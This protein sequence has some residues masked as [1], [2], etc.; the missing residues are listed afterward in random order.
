[1]GLLMLFSSAFAQEVQLSDDKQKPE[2]V[3]IKLLDWL[4]KD[5]TLQNLD[6]SLERTKTKLFMGMIKTLEN[7]DSGNLKYHPELLK[8]WKSLSHIDP[9]FED[10]LDEN[11]PYKRYRF[12]RNRRYNK[13]KTVDFFG[14][15]KAWKDLQESNPEYFKGL[16]EKFRLDK[17]DLTTADVVD[18]ISDVKYKNS[19]VKQK[20]LDI[21]KALKTRAS[22]PT[23]KLLTGQSLTDLKKK[24]DGLQKD[25]YENS[26]ELY[27]NYLKDYEHVCDMNTISGLDPVHLTEYIC[28]YEND[29][30]KPDIDHLLLNLADVITINKLDTTEQPEIPPVPVDPD[31]I[32]IVEEDELDIVELDYEVNPNPN[33]YYCKR[34]PNVVD[35]L[36]IHHTGEPKETTPEDINEAHIARSTDGDPWYMIGY[37]YLISET[38][39]GGTAESPSVIQGRAPEVRGAHAGGYTRVLSKKR[40]KELSKYKIQC[41]RD[42]DWIETNMAAEFQMGKISGNITTIGIAIL[43]N[44][45]TSYTVSAGGVVLIKN[46][47]GGKKVTYPS[48]AVLRKTA[49]L[50]CHLQKQYPNIKRI[51]P[52]RYF[53]ATNCPGS[54]IARLQTITTYAN[55]LGCEFNTPEFKQ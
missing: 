19:G 45:E 28:S 14:A 13:I 37:N 30:V 32:D 2:E 48:E 47:K 6:K 31:Q 5:L 53:K 18:N 36:T 34:D 50:A 54:I 27:F 42:D 40:R 33:A 12:W 44:Y 55:E 25:I 29:E 3:C 43:G 49:Q 17:W 41:G 38:A 10:Y 22:N 26:S 15:V 39:H 4:Y 51:V 9:E 24:I 8:L 35:T 7:V 1:M 52:H 23:K 20:L 21:S 46:V 16:E 11:A